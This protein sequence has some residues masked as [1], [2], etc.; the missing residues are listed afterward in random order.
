MALS[1]QGKTALVTGGSRGIGRAIAERLAADGA[2]VV[3]NY[4]RNED[5]AHQ[6]VKGISTKGGKAIAIQADVS[7]PTEVRRLFN[8]AEKAMGGLDIVVANAGVHIVKPLIENTEAD[9]DYI[10]D[11]NTRGVFFTLQEAGRRVRDYSGGMRRRLGI[12]VA[13]LGAPPLLIVDEPTTGLDLPSRQQLREI[14]L[15]AAGQRIVLLSTH[16]ASDV[17]A[18]ASRLLVMQRGRLV[19]DG[20]VDAHLV[21]ARA[22]D[23]ARQAVDPAR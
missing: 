2:A 14:L 21:A 10:F 8:E 1:L 4:A 15:R 6:I 9:Y 19:F 11:I 5:L 20:S 17:E 3:I 12:A 16:I 23:A 22:R 13:L 18:I 7:K